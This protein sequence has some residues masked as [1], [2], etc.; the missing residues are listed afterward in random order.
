MPKVTFLDREGTRHVVEAVG[1]ETLLATARRHRIAIEGAC[2]GS[3]S[4]STCHVIVD[5]RDIS[6]LVPPRADEDDMLDLAFG[7][8]ATSRLACQIVVSDNLDGLTVAIPEN[9]GGGG[10]RLVSA[11]GDRLARSA[12]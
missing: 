7:L 11:Q 4:C 1:G 6:R 5:P 2:E 9:F 3:L 12:E 8:T 10:P